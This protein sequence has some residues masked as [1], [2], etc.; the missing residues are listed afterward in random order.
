V[1]EYS[2]YTYIS[3]GVG[4]LDFVTAVTLNTVREDVDLD[5]ATEITDSS[6][7]GDK[8]ENTAPARNA[9]ESSASDESIDTDSAP[10]ESNEEATSE[11]ESDQS[12][13]SN[14]SSPE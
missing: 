1:H 7:P 6:A 8:G 11:S 3:P 13:S 10:S 14:A 4:E 9:D 2:I 12:G 5:A